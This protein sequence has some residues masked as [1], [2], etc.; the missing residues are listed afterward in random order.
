MYQFKRKRLHGFNVSVW[1]ILWTPNFF[2][3]MLIMQQSATSS[4][5]YI[6]SDWSED[7]YQILQTIEY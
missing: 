4:S 5:D 7:N 2:S 1:H 6:N 3:F